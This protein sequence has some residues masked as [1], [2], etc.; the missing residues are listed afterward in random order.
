MTVSFYISATAPSSPPANFRQTL[1]DK[2]YNAIYKISSIISRDNVPKFRAHLNGKAV[3]VYVI[4]PRELSRY[5]DV[6]DISGEEIQQ[7]INLNVPIYYIPNY[8]MEVHAY[9]YVEQ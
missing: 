5:A 7:H 2:L 4:P 1:S 3:T 6:L 9:S 8:P